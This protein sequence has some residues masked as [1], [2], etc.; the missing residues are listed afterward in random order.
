MR[1]AGLRREETVRRSRWII[2]LGVVLAMGLAA[3][4]KSATPS[5]GGGTGA[6]SSAK[7]LDTL[8]PGV[9]TVGSCLAYKPFEYYQGG[10]L[11]GF[12]VEIIQAI[13]KKLGLTV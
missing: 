2:T 11:K 13:A 7:P 1:I 12:D 5:S 6:S 8:K 10:T 3:C 4:S 9:L